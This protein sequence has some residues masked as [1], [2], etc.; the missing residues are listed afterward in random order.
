M[1]KCCLLQ[2]DRTKDTLFFASDQSLA[3]LDGSLPADY[4]F[5]E[6]HPTNVAFI[7][8]NSGQIAQ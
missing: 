5:G 1:T 4:G 2:V 6:G 8:G 3:Y 7:P